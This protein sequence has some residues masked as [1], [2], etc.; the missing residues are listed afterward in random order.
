MGSK[1][2][3]LTPEQ[4]RRIDRFIELSAKRGIT[5]RLN[6]NHTKVNLISKSG[7]VTGSRPVSDFAD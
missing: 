4:R 2:Q 6:H 3:N 7:E 5:V 1:R